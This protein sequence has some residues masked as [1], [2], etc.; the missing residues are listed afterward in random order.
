M[1][2]ILH[3]MSA[4]ECGGETNHTRIQSGHFQCCL[5]SGKYLQILLST[6]GQVPESQ[7]PLPHVRLELRMLQTVYK[8]PLGDLRYCPTLQVAASPSEAFSVL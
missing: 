4:F 5:D 2:M 3:Y 7:K 6:E 8:L 1:L